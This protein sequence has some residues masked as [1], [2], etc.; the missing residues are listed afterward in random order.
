MKIPFNKL[1]ILLGLTGNLIFGQQKIQPYVDE[2]VELMSILFRLIDAQE[3]SSRN[4]EL[5]VQDIEKHFAPVKSDAFLNQMKEVRNKNGVGYDAV[6][7]MAVHLDIKNGKVT[8]IKE[9]KNTLEKRWPTEDVPALVNS[10]NT[11]YKKSN[12][13]QFFKN[14]EADYKQAAKA[15][16]DSIMSRFNQDWYVKFYGKQ[17]NEEYK[18][19]IGYGNG[20]G[21]YGP[22]VSPEGNKDIVYAIVSGGKF[23]GRTVSFS[24]GYAPILIHEFNHSFVNY[25]LETKDYKK[26][27]AEAGVKIQ[28]AV[29]KPMEEQAYSSW[30]TIINESIVRAAVIVY[31]KENNFSAKEIQEEYT[32]QGQR[33]F[34][35][36]PELVQLLE[37]YQKNRKKYPSIEAFYPNIVTFF[38]QLGENIDAAI[39]EYGVH[40][41]HIKSM[42]PDINGKTDVDPNL[43][44][45]IVRFDKTLLG[46]GFSINYGDLGKEGMPIN[47]RPE[48]QDGNN[49]LKLEMELKPNTE[50][51]FILTGNRFISTDGYPLEDYKVKFKTK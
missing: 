10:I 35:W 50:Y 37:N 28:N 29:R 1:F 17:P 27:L 24:S 9:S 45:L 33:Y 19:V 44:Q 8:Q 5:Y 26:Q 15:Y 3:Y 18:I 11:F 21:N 42:T 43:K 20:G 13:H 7:S 32:E 2:R 12:F 31:M 25:I 4:N 30:E 14:H 48:Y 46:N 38:K 34:I 49:A 41:P 40:R 6:M 36:M 22:R 47:K 51:E 23:N 39:K 16:S